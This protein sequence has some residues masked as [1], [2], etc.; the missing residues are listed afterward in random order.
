MKRKIASILTA[1][2]LVAAASFFTGCASTSWPSVATSPITQD[3]VE[4]TVSDA[5]IL[6]LANNKN[7]PALI[8]DFQVGATVLGDLSGSTNVLSA[9]QVNALL[10]QSGSTNQ[11]VNALI[12]GNVTSLVNNYEA[13]TTN[14]V[15][16]STVVDTWLK[17]DAAG[18]QNALNSVQP[19][20]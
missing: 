9:A 12:A 4:S 19:A 7:S 2:L 14:A 6:V 15:I 3:V 11:L 10:V 8:T 5:T 17:W 18:I 13:S 20:Q 16:P 1:T